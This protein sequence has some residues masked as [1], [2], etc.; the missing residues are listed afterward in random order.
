MRP[1]FPSF[2]MRMRKILLGGSDVP[3]RP[4]GGACGARPQALREL[5]G[6]RL[7]SGSD[8]PLQRPGAQLLRE[9]LDADRSGVAGFYQ[10]GGE[11]FDI[12]LALSTEAAV[13]RGL[14]DPIR[15]R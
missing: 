2:F 12:E 4:A 11:A 6:G 1:V 3:R 9:H 13:L 5:R 8:G 7:V 14:L 15:S 10:P